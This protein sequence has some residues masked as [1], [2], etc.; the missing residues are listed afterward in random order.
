M[1][2][3]TCLKPATFA[4]NKYMPGDIVPAEAIPAGRVSA[5]MRMGLIA[6][7]KE[8]APNAQEAT[9]TPQDGA[10][11][12]GGIVI[13]L[14]RDGGVFEAVTTHAGL[15]QATDVLQMTVENAQ[16]AIA[17]IEDETVLALIHGLDSRKGVQNAAEK[18]ALVIG[19]SKG[20][21]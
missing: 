5:V 12:P 17:E 13:P 16:K 1:R 6:E 18:R 3:F 8:A 10:D 15:L 2:A 20:A 7:H 11:G 9:Q 19:D 14:T 4:G 21:E